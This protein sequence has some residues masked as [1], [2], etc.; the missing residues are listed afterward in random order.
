[1]HKTPDDIHV[2][3]S[4]STCQVE[5]RPLASAPISSPNPKPPCSRPKRNKVCPPGTVETTPAR[6]RRFDLPQLPLSLTLLVSGQRVHCVSS[7]HSF[8]SFSHQKDGHSS[9]TFSTTAVFFNTISQTR[10]P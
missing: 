9:V 7:C 10:L 8:Q 3:F 4:L 2:E 5:T 1:M 6:P